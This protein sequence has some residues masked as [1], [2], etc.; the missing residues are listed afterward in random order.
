MSIVEAAASG[1]YVVTTD[2]GGIPEVL[3]HEA[4][5]LCAPSVRILTAEIL[6]AI[7]EKRNYQSESAE[8]V[9]QL[10]AR[11]MSWRAIAEQL[12]AIYE[13]KRLPNSCYWEMIQP[14]RPG[15]SIL[16]LIYFALLYVTVTVC[17][18]LL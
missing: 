9:H 16:C 13:T 12:L 7:R 3:P 14:E 15:R 5:T 6:T 17:R 4:R 10:I 11:T 2:V 18:W 1:L 8:R